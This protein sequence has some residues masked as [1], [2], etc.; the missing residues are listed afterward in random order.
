M[1]IAESSVGV[2]CS[3]FMLQHVQH[4]ETL[5]AHFHRHLIRRDIHYLSSEHGQ[6]FI[7]AFDAHMRAYS[8]YL[9]A[10]GA[11][12]QPT[13]CIQARALRK[14]QLESRCSCGSRDATEACNWHWTSD[15]AGGVA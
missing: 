2:G 6:M 7:D 12:P 13:H 14:S 10:S 4:R 8:C 9:W 5:F 3:H 1:S 15:E 11:C